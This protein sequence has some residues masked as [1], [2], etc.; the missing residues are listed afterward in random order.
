MAVVVIDGVE[1]VPMPQAKPT[2]AP[3]FPYKGLYLLLDQLRTAICEFRD[4]AERP[5]LQSSVDELDRMAGMANRAVGI[6]IGVPRETKA[7]E[8]DAT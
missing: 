7:R 8:S 4:N 3:Q 2:A 1:Y 5:R 6:V